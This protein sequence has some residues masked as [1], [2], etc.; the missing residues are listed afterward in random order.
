LH[1]ELSDTA[2]DDKNKLHSTIHNNQFSVGYL[3]RFSGLEQSLYK[4]P[5][6]ENSNLP[7]HGLYVNDTP[8]TLYSR[9]YQRDRRTTQPKRAPSICLAGMQRQMEGVQ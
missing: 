7:Y 4:S 1:I 6:Y 2:R 3:N 9:C 8:R 5:C